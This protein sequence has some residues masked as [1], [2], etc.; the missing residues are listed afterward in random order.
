MKDFENIVSAIMEAFDLTAEE[1]E[2]M[3]Q[4]FIEE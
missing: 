3:A 4:E 1:A 2:T